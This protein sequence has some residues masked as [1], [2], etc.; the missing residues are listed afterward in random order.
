M[1]ELQYPKLAGLLTQALAK[2]GLNMG[3]DILRLLL[4]R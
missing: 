4:P 1:A 2:H 3:F